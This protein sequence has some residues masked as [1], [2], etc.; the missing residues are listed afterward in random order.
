MAAGQP[1]GMRCEETAYPLVCAEANRVVSGKPVQADPGSYLLLIRRRGFADQRYPMVVPRGGE[2]KGSLSL[3]PTDAV[4]PG[5]VFIPEGPFVYGGDPAASSP[6]PKQI[7]RLEGFC[8][9]RK[10]VTSE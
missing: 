10:E 6:G 7:L 1:S 9:G 2:A 8:I 4:P 3:Q 5:F